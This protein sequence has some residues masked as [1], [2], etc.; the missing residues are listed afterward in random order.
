MK[1]K[2]T[3]YMG[4]HKE[5]YLP[6]RTALLTKHMLACLKTEL[7]GL[8]W[9]SLAESVCMA[10]YTRLSLLLCPHPAALEICS[11]N[12]WLDSIETFHPR[13]LRKHIPANRMKG[14]FITRSPLCLKQTPT[15][16][17]FCFLHFRKNWAPSEKSLEREEKPKTG[18]RLKGGRQEAKDKGGAVEI[19]RKVELYFSKA[20]ATVLDGR[21]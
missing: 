20:K 13:L 15:E 11:C 18:R 19:V 2:T 21:W 17:L 5:S 4:N 7:L 12:L 14:P 9:V 3:L 16:R 6:E 1:N 8:P 10:L